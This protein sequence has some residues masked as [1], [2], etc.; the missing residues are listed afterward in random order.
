M[1]FFYILGSKWLRA[2]HLRNSLEILAKYGKESADVT[3]PSSLLQITT[4]DLLHWCRSRGFTPM[5]QMKRAL[6]KGK[7]SICSLCGRN[8]LTQHCTISLSTALIRPVPLDLTLLKSSTR[9]N[10][11]E[12][13]PSSWISHMPIASLNHTLAR[14]IGDWI[15]AFR[16]DLLSPS[17]EI[18]TFKANSL[19]SADAPLSRLTKRSYR[20]RSFRPLGPEDSLLD[21][22]Q[23]EGFIVEQD[24]ALGLLASC[25]K[26][27]LKRLIQKSL[28]ELHSQH[29]IQPELKQL[30]SKFQSDE[31][32]ILTNQ[33]PPVRKSIVPYHVYLAIRQDPILHFLDPDSVIVPDEV[34]RSL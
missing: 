7:Y 34:T 30:S 12:P 31:G 26:I 15:R 17:K 9:R 33:I 11:E 28:L 23:E 2:K 24:Q 18:D 6:P 13:E 21:E 22:S 5:A 20:G 4:G 14:M 27:F 1:R 16:H 10:Q 32:E 19:H 3:L 8:H 29:P 25:L